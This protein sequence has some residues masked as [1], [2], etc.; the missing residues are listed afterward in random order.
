[1]KSGNATLTTP[2]VTFQN[3]GRRYGAHWALKGIDGVLNP[4]EIVALL[5]ENGSGKSTLLL[6]LARI[7]KPHS[8]DL[9]FLPAIESHLVA[10]HPMAY[11]QLP[12]GHNLALAQSMHARS[13]AD[14]NSAL[15]YWNISHLKDKP[16]N[17]LSRG[18][19]QRFLLARAQVAAAH[20]LLLDEPFTGLD[21]RSEELLTAFMRSEAA[22]GVAILISE[23]DASRARRLAHR[24]YYLEKGKLR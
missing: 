16:V 9:K 12:I 1:M 24:Q 6:T 4:G 18:Q 20:I 23:H 17:T 15:K 7:L 21:A 11:M 19:M 14:V 13:A 22:R 8:G 2:I 5:G 3:L 10:H